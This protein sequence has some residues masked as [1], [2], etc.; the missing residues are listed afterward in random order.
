[1]KAKYVHDCEVCKLIHV[2]DKYD[3]YI[4]PDSKKVE[5]S[6]VVCRMSDDGP[7]YSSCSVEQLGQP[8]DFRSEA[9]D[10][11]VQFLLRTAAQ[12]LIG[13]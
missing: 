3:I 4:C 12:Q 1:M 5:W 13:S 7:D 2:T 9:R 8:R 6:T 11:A 10:A